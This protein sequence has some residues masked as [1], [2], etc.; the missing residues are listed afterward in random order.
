VISAAAL[1]ESHLLTDEEIVAHVVAGRTAL[2][3][4]LMRR[5]NERVYRLARSI[6]RND[7]EAEDVMQQAYVNAYSHLGQFSGKA[8]FS[9]WLLR[10]ASNEALARVRRSGRYEPF[11]DDRSP[12]EDVSNMPAPRNPEQQASSGELRALLTSAIDD[13]PDGNREVFVL[14]EVEGLSTADTAAVLDVSEDVVKTRLSRA[15]AALRRAVEEQIGAVAPDVFR[16]YR[17]RCDRLV[18]CVMERV[19]SAARA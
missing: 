3:E 18:A 2:F 4:V 9:T 14:R 10:I 19:E 6:V 7:E 12:V 11:E 5:H 15:R 1:T 13:L 16:F 17:P 8:R